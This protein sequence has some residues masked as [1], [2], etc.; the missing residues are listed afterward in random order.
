MVSCAEARVAAVARMMG[1]D[2]IVTGGLLG[3]KLSWMNRDGTNQTADGWIDRG[4]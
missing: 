1:A 2:L 4:R 3:V